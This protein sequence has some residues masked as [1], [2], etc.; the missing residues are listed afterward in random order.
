M[1]GSN[2][3]FWCSLYIRVESVCPVQSS[4]ICQSLQGNCLLHRCVH[5]YVC[6]CVCVFDT[7]VVLQK[8]FVVNDEVQ[9]LV[10]E[11]VKQ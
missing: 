2:S 3:D 5:V 11:F 1:Y 9:R 7:F 8:G 6:V 10:V 4:L